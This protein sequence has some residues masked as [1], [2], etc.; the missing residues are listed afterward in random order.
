MALPP[1]FFSSFICHSKLKAFGR[2]LIELAQ[3]T[4]EASKTS[5]Q[6]HARNLQVNWA[7]KLRLN[8][9]KLDGSSVPGTTVTAQ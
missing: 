1:H 2:R 8:A 9:I 7:R 5:L 3:V 6:E 4:P